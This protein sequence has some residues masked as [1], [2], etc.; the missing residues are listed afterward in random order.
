MYYCTFSLETKTYLTKIYNTPK[1]NK[2]STILWQTN[3][4]KQISTFFIIA[5]DR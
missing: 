2:F 5:F 3:I 1:N 4:G